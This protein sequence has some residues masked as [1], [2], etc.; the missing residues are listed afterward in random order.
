MSGSSFAAILDRRGALNRIFLVCKLSKPIG[1]GVDRATGGPPT[2]NAF[3]VVLDGSRSWFRYHHLFADLLQLE[4]RR[5]ALDELTQGSLETARRYLGL[6][7]RASA[8]APVGQQ[9]QAQLLGITRL[10]HA[11]QRGDLPAVA[12]EAGRLQAIADAADST[13]PALGEDLRAL[14]LIHSAAPSSGP[15]RSTTET[16]TWS[17]A[18]R[19]RARSDA[20]IWSSP[21]WPT[22]QG[23]SPS[24][25]LP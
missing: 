6:A 9:G 4:L 3:V 10:L 22:G 19:W 2:A 18:W 17:G 25:R 20:P 24:D 23:L 12:K 5:T 21:A 11:R 14:A 1:Q 16:G 15:P 7:E 8:S 13:R